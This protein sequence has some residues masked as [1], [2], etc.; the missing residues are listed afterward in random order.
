MYV[1]SGHGAVR[2]ECVCASLVGTVEYVVSGVCALLY[3]GHGAVRDECVCVYV[4]SGHGAVRGECVCVYPRSQASPQL[5]GHIML[6]VFLGMRLCIC[7]P[8]LFLTILSRLCLSIR[9]SVCL[10]VCLSIRLSV[11]LLSSLQAPEVLKDK[12]YHSSVSE[13]V[14]LG[15]SEG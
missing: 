15:N 11:C 3:S 1:T 10:S 4:T 5:C 7:L 9:L 6:K 14:G 12:K 8:F 13:E 2:G